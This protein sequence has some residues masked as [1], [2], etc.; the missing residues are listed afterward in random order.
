MFETLKKLVNER[1]TALENILENKF[2]E[3]EGKTVSEI[4]AEL[5]ALR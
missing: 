1:F 5:A 3:L 4:E 2:G